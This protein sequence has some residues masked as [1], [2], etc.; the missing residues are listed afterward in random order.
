LVWQHSS[1]SNLNPNISSP[2]NPN[3]VSLGSVA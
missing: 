3:S 1:P 2:R